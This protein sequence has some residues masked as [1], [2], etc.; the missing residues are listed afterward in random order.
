M[1][2]ILKMPFINTMVFNLFELDDFDIKIGGTS[3]SKIYQN[4]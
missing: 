2:R 4:D 3:N 1:T